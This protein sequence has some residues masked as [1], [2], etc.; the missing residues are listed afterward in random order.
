MCAKRVLLKF[1]TSAYMLMIK[2]QYSVF[3]LILLNQ[4]Y[5]GAYADIEPQPNYDDAT[6]P[7]VSFFY[8]FNQ[9]YTLDKKMY[10]SLT[11][12]NFF[13]IRIRLVNRLKV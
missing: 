3:A 4:L 2:H 7:T 1:M 13:I 9:L 6:I 11:E 8:Y 5:H 10:S 12:S